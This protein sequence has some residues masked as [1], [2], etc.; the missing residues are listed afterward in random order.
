MITINHTLQ[1]R[2]TSLICS[3]NSFSLS[4]PLDFWLVIWKIILSPVPFLFVQIAFQCKFLNFTRFYIPSPPNPSFLLLAFLRQDQAFIHIFQIRYLIQ[5]IHQR[6][7]KLSL[8]VALEF[9]LQISSNLVL[10]CKFGELL[11]KFTY[12]RVLGE[13]MIE[14]NVEV[15]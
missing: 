10:R 9:L 8:L 7:I 4:F 1:L 3:L 13:L 14:V 11:D 5:P 2:Q 15:E 12:F 6:K